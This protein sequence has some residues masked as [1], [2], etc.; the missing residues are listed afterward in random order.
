MP[1]LQGEY[2][3]PHFDS[4]GQ[5]D[6]FFTDLGVPVTFLRTSF[7]WENFIY[8]GMGP[9]KGQDGKLA[10]TFPLGDKKLPGIAAQDIGK[11]ALQARLREGVSR[12]SQPR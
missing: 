8:F 1:T 5:S 7:Y 10:I 6:H 2:K 11:C 9:Q 4:K 3:V 12:R